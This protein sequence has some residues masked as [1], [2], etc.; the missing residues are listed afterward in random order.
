[1]FNYFDYLYVYTNKENVMK[2]NDCVKMVHDLAVEKG[3]YNP[4]KSDVESCALMHSEISEAVEELRVDNPSIYYTNKK[5]GKQWDKEELPELFDSSEWKP[6]GTMIEIADLVIRAF[7]FCGN[8]GWDLEKA[9]KI[10]YE[11]N[12]S[13]SK[14]H[15][16]KNC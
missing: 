11:Y 8:K 12:K 13:R 3:W 14:R 4:P 2:I 1:M 6:N 9:I 7:D 10:K 15:G 5:T 16:G